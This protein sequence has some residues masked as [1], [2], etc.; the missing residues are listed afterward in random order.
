MTALDEITQAM[1][2]TNYFR[3]KMGIGAV[4]RNP[5]EDNLKETLRTLDAFDKRMDP[6]KTWHPEVYTERTNLVW[7][8]FDIARELDM[9]VSVSPAPE[10]P[11]G[12][13]V[14]IMLPLKNDYYP[15]TWLIP[16]GKVYGQT[17]EMRTFRISEYTKDLP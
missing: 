15:V 6:L 1:F 4:E 8:A 12:I 14:S 9:E 13:L 3:Q 2:P 7:L 10:T 17:K 11:D 5:W 16:A